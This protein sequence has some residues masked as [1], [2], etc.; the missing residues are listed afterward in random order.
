MDG[1]LRRVLRAGIKVSMT[2]EGSLV[3][4]SLCAYQVRPAVRDGRRKG[5]RRSGGVVSYSVS[6][7]R[8]NSPRVH[9]KPPVRASSAST[10]DWH[11]LML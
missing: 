5:S 7:T 4:R 8:R 2:G 6:R 3:S 11:A 1:G 9:S 10:L